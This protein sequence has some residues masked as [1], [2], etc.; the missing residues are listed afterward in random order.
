LHPYRTFGRQRTIMIKFKRLSIPPNATDEEL[1][2]AYLRTGMARYL[3]DLYERYLPM[4][5]GVCLKILKDPGKA[6]DATMGIY[7]VLD[8]KV[9]EH[10]VTSFRGWLYVLARNYCIMEW[11]KNQRHHVDL[12]APEQFGQWD[13]AEEMAEPEMDDMRNKN[14]L[15]DCLNK[16]QAL[17]RSCVQMFYYE[18][19]SYKEIAEL[20]REDVGKVRSCIQNGKRNLKLCLDD[21]DT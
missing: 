3:G 1:L 6:E 9:R 11:R 12:Y 17:Q 14:K 4:V 10:P 18:D 19:K 13:V 8:K 5:Y 15:Q 16:L 2:A 20:T 21:H 7:E